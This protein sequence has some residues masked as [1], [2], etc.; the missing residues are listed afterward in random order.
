ME[1]GK[2]SS[3]DAG[4]AN[5]RMPISEQQKKST[6]DKKPKKSGVRDPEQP[7]DGSEPGNSSGGSKK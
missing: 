6:T 2:D 4:K 1:T 3:T 7:K 5:Q